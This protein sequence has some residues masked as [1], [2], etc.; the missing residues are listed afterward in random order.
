MH[1]FGE[2]FLDK[3][4]KILYKYIRKVRNESCFTRVPNWDS[5]INLAYKRR[6]Q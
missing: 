6:K 1:N 5:N 4:L 3:T 2:S